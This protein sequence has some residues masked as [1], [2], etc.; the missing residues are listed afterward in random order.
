VLFLQAGTI[1][2]GFHGEYWNLS[3]KDSEAENYR[4]IGIIQK[5]LGQENTKNLQILG[6]KK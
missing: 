5:M 2:E 6:E 1:M 4:M 3:D